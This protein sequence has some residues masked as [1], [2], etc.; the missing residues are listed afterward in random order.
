MKYYAP[1]VKKVTPLNIDGEAKEIKFD[2]EVMR[3]IFAKHIYDNPL[4]GFRELYSNAIRACKEARDEHGADPSIDIIIDKSLLDFTMIEHDSMGITQEIFDEV[5]TVLGHSGNWNGKFPGQFGIGIAAY[6]AISDNMFIESK[7]RNGDKL[8]YLIREMKTCE[9]IKKNNPVK[10][11]T[12]GTKIKLK[13]QKL[14]SNEKN[15]GLSLAIEYIKNLAMFAGVETNLTIYG[16]NGMKMTKKIGSFRPETYLAND[17]N[18]DIFKINKDDYELVLSK[19]NCEFRKTTL[20]GIPI[21]AD[22]FNGVIWLNHYLNIKDERKYPPVASRDSFTN[23]SIEAIKTMIINDIKEWLMQYSYVSTIDE[24]YR[25]PITARNYAYVI[26]SDILEYNL[27]DKLTPLLDISYIINK[28][29]RI[30]KKG[31]MG[32]EHTLESIIRKNGIDKVCCIENTDQALIKSLSNYIVIDA[33]EDFETMSKY[34]QDGKNI[35]DAKKVVRLHYGD[36]SYNDEKIIT[37]SEISNEFVEPETLIRTKNPFK[38][39]KMAHKADIN[40]TY[41]FFDGEYVGIKLEDF[42]R[43][44]F[45]KMHDGMKGSEIVEK[46]HLIVAEENFNLNIKQGDLG[47]IHICMPEDDANDL[48]LA[49]VLNEGK[50]ELTI[51]NFQEICARLGAKYCNE[52]SDVN[53]YGCRNIDGI[54]KSLDKI[55]DKKLRGYIALFYSIACNNEPLDIIGKL[56]EQVEKHLKQTDNII[57]G[58]LHLALNMENPIYSD[59]NK[60][61]ENIL[62]SF[63]SNVKNK[64]IVDVLGGNNYDESKEGISYVLKGYS[65]IGGEIMQKLK[66]MNLIHGI[67][68]IETSDVDGILTTKVWLY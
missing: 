29:Y 47:N 55:P 68:K 21:D 16:K 45:E 7:A 43:N 53:F 51:L 18:N 4:A 15:S 25:L 11:K 56:I 48:A 54:L 42:I 59:F 57:D 63:A 3:D 2:V 33:N 6:Y 22:W 5:L 41:R 61:W 39:A 26:I 67:N 58:L 24:W 20:V 64:A 28:N 12:Y 13:L 10:L 8:S 17:D 60:T 23:E 65:T 62:A 36:Y 37:E 40:K 27:D 9:N 19:Y 66:R 32:G 34:I 14:N 52:V 44:A 1:E 50:T 46:N 38:Y 30:Y 31:N 35:K 49:N